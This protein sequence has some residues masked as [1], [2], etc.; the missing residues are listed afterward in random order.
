MDLGIKNRVAIVAGASQGLGKATARA[1]AQE[2][3]RT[4]LCAR[5]ADALQA[6]AEEINR[7]GTG[8]AWPIKCDVTQ[9][10]EIVELVR[11]V[12]E[13]WGRIDI[14]VNNAGGPPAGLFENFSLASWRDALELNLL[15]T[16]HLCR[17]VAPHM[18]ARKWGR[19]VNITSIAAKQ[20]VPGLMLSSAARAGV[21]GFAKAL[22]NELAPENITVNSVCPGY[23]RTNRLIELAE[24]TAKRE[25]IGV[26]D[27][28]RRWQEAIPMRRLGEPEEL[29]AMITFLCSEQAGYITG[30]TIQVDG[31]FLKSIF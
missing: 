28:Y 6:A 22:S 25:S 15:S 31:G 4:V 13:K 9:E 5:N 8:Q 12:A 18:R 2:G 19:I 24:A 21:L 17:M 30:N 11:A 1:F 7:S 3:V 20:P 29:A 27:V 16:V 23:T 14:L 26:D 10:Q